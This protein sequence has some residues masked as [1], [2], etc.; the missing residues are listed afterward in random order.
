MEMNKPL[1]VL[2]V[3]DSESDTQLLLRLL[4]KAGYEAQSERVESAEAM[5][6][7]LG[8]GPWDL[9]LA[10]Y[11]MPQFSAPDALALLKESGLDLPFIVVSG[12]IGEAT[13]VAAMKAGAHDYLMKDN[14]ARLVPA[15]ERELRE[16]ANRAGKRRTAEALRESELRNRLLLETATDAIVLT[17]TEGTIHFTNPAVAQVF[18]YQPEELV[19]QNLSLLQP[20]ALRKA[21]AQG[22]AQYLK[23]GQ[24]HAN[25]RAREMPARRKDGT[26]ILVEVAFSH[27]EFEGRRWFVGFIRDITERKRTE[28]ALQESQ[29]QFRVA[30]EIQQHLFPK[31]APEIAGFDIAGVSQPAEATGGDYFDYLRMDQGCFGLVVGDV[32]GHGVGPALLMSEARAYLRLLAKDS[33][34]VGQ[35]MTRANAALALD[36]GTERFVT[37]LLA[38]LDPRDH[39]LAYVNAGHPP[40]Y[41]FA[42]SGEIRASLKRTSLPL[43]IRTDTVYASAPPL[44]LERGDMVVLLTDGFE[45]AVAPDERV[46]GIERVFNLVREHRERPARE[47]VQALCDA[48]HNFLQDSPRADDVT[49]VVAKVQN[50]P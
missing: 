44:K 26:E 40:G 6:A 28:R 29:E 45:E 35:I 4:R 7:A 30:R 19:G 22:V 18:G 5:E 15:V 8:R 23:T 46:F 17:D 34:E 12:G 13:A 27:M 1:R 31:S 24:Q 9:V 11:R 50:T 21:H 43:G 49:V 41:V 38:K 10:D 37:L 33:D 2:I 25:W 42:A 20:E 16:A 48:V 14:L 39:T 36:V 32:T 47:I 3:E